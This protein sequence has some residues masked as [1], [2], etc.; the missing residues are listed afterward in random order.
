MDKSRTKCFGARQDFCLMMV[1][2]IVL[3]SFGKAGIAEENESE[4]HY[5]MIS[6]VEYAGNGQFQNQVEALFTV[7]KLSLPDDKVQYFIS[8]KDFD[9]VRN[10][11]NYDL[12]LDKTSWRLLQLCRPTKLHLI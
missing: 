9:P 8:T 12:V 7:N 10:N 2:S 6:T 5:K 1:L 4:E 11:W 3:L